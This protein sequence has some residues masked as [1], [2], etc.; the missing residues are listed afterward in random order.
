MNLAL[1]VEP[2]ANF[3]SQRRLIAYAPIFFRQPRRDRAVFAPGSDERHEACRATGH[4]I[5]GWADEKER[6]D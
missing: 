6:S 4:S 1:H 3:D 2:E 5:A